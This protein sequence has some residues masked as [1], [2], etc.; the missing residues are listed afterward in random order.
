[1]CEF[2][3]TVCLSIVFKRLLFVVFLSIHDQVLVQYFKNRALPD[4]L[5][6]P[7]PGTCKQ[8]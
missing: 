1:M 7:L 6:L 4:T 8:K 2:R 5:Y 3:S